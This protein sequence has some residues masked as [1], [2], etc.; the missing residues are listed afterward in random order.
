[1]E[2]ID[3]EDQDRDEEMDVFEH[4]YNFRYEEQTGAYL[5]THAREVPESMRRKD[6]HRKEV[7][8]SK[9]ER[10]DDEKRRKNEE[11]NKLKS[12]KKDE[13]MEKLKKAEFISGGR[14][15]ED[16]RIL[17]K[18]EKELKTE[19][20]PDLYDRNMSKMFDEKY[21]EMSDSEIKKSEKKKGLNLKLLK[22]KVGINEES[23]SENGNDNE[24]EEEEDDE[25]EREIYERELTKSLKNQVDT[26]MQG[27]DAWYVCDGCTKPIDGGKFRFDCN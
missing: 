5:T 3:K 10:K 27:Y 9:K 20:I 2:D 7:R 18:A 15:L 8:D 13:I 11:L 19:F 24:D 25:Q 16:K 12:L 4:Q 21:Y 1:M 22:D 26:E 6:D 23:K 17:E 14:I